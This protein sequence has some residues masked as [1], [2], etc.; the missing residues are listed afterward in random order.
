MS[1]QIKQ[2]T[3]AYPLVFFMTDSSDHLSGKTGLSPTVTLSKSG[4]SFA[5]PSG[6]VSEIANGWYKVAGN[7]TDSNTLGPLALHAT[8]TG[9]DATDMLF[10]VIAFDPQDSVRLGLTALPNAAA[11]ASGGLPIDVATGANSNFGIVDR[12]TAQAATGTTLQ[13][14]SAAAFADSELV[15][16][17]ILITGGST[18]VGQARII[19]GYVGSTDTATVDTWTT[20]PTGTITY[21][22]FGSPPGSSGNPVPADVTKWNGTAVSTPATAGIPEVNVKN[23]NNVSASSVT[24]IN[25]NMGTTQPVNFTGTGASALAKSDVVDIAGAA[26]SA[27]TAQLGVN[28]VN[29]KGSAAPNNTGD[30]FAR[31]GAPVGASMSADVASVQTDTTAIKAKTNSLTFTVAG[32][33][34]ANIQSINDVTVTGNGS[35]GNKFGV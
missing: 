29:W 26:V 6:S 10:E 21:I 33:V 22:V 7:A 24:T 17:T 8:G 18:G 11:G 15:G 32:Q 16:C 4:G 12:G 5:S 31:L 35:S 25:A 2:S 14:R 30:A 3:T 34:D 27:S 1:Y 28:V 13:L 19:T 23:V 9:A 20:T